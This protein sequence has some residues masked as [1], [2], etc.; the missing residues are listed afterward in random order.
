MP[1]VSWVN[2]TQRL[3]AQRRNHRSLRNGRAW[4]FGG[5]LVVDGKFC[6][7]DPD[8]S[9]TKHRV[10]GSRRRQL[11]KHQQKLSSHSSCVFLS[12]CYLVLLGRIAS[13]SG[14]P[15]SLETALLRRRDHPY[16]TKSTKNRRQ[17]IDNPFLP[18]YPTNSCKN[19]KPAESWMS[20]LAPTA[21]ECCNANFAWILDQCVKNSNFI[22][23]SSPTVSP[24]T[25]GTTSATPAE[26]G[27]GDDSTIPVESGRVVV[28][29]IPMHFLNLPSDFDLNDTQRE[30]MESIVSNAAARSI[31]NLDVELLSV[32]IVDE[33]WNHERIL[34][35]EWE[36]QWTITVD[37]NEYDTTLRT[38]KSPRV[39]YNTHSIKELFNRT[40]DNR[41]LENSLTLWLEIIVMESI[42]APDQIRS[43]ILYA[44][45]DHKFDT[46]EMIRESW[47]SDLITEDV[48]LEI[49]DIET[50]PPPS[51]LPTKSP[52]YISNASPFQD[53]SSEDNKKGAKFLP[54]WIVIIFAFLFM[55]IFGVLIYCQKEQ[56]KK[57]DLSMKD[58][59]QLRR[60]ERSRDM[61]RERKKSPHEKKMMPSQKI[62]SNSS[63]VSYERSHAKLA[64]GESSRSKL[65]MGESSRTKLSMHESIPLQM[66][67]GESSGSKSALKYPQCGQSSSFSYALPVDAVPSELFEKSLSFS[68]IDDEQITMDKELMESYIR[69]QS[70]EEEHEKLDDGYDAGKS[71][72]LNSFGN[73]SN[74]SSVV[75]GNRGVDPDEEASSKEDGDSVLG[76]LYY[77][78][79]SSS[80][81]SRS[82]PDPHGS[83]YRRRS[84]LTGASTSSRS[85][86]SMRSRR[87]ARSKNSRYSLDGK[88][89]SSKSYQ[90]PRRRKKTLKKLD[91]ESQT[92]HSLEDES[93]SRVNSVVSSL[94]GNMNA[95]ATYVSQQSTHMTAESSFQR[96]YIYDV[97]NVDSNQRRPATG[98]RAPILGD[99][100][101]MMS[102]ASGL[103]L[104]VDTTGDYV[105]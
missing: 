18:D 79:A 41:L 14:I 34:R 89:S 64:M 97:S 22:Q 33:I 65:T 69:R 103:S 59:H 52:T 78:G 48:I 24:T 75:H 71:S 49:G 92:Q 83:K 74:N 55:I 51:P 5:S 31:E 84:S 70:Q 98:E 19:D 7:T 13:V 56:D 94:Y 43:T 6:T 47:G 76:L 91:E 73:V 61:H 28:P 93:D 104:T 63:H 54:L 57:E 23:T 85:R 81:D 60:N 38:A 62:K 50:T 29:L 45:Q 9:L 32:N 10:V 66:T 67:M 35:V 40:Q 80:E 4:S 99:A 8:H 87:S 95:A 27:A 46:I 100:G 72:Y 25:E 53:V 58:L 90:R 82:S 30:G 17:S 86:S 36:R 39:K 1:N 101:S 16:G 26:D 102:A 77:A 12:A 3:M 20:Q 21:L 96:A 105:L 44:L 88:S 68:Y 15:S 37:E 42:F 2:K 11:S